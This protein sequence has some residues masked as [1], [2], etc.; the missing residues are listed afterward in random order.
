ML[1]Q[2]HK[3]TGPQYVEGVSRQQQVQPFIGG[4]LPNQAHDTVRQQTQASNGATT[5]LENKTKQEEHK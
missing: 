1:E 4:I 5:E 3:V 2:N